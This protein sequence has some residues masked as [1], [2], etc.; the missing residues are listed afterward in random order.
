M[1]LDQIIII[2]FVALSVAGLSWVGWHSRRKQQQ[3]D[4][5]QPL[6]KKQ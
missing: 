5:K 4:T 2:A 3:G 6:V 1:A